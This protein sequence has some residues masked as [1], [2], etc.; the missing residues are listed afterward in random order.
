MTPLAS[1]V[2]VLVNSRVNGAEGFEADAMCNW[3]PPASEGAVQEMSM[4]VRSGPRTAENP[5]GTPGITAGSG[6]G[7]GVGVSVGVGVAVGVGVGVGVGLGGVGRL[8]I[9]RSIQSDS[10]PAP[11]LSGFHANW[12]DPASGAAARRARRQVL[13]PLRKCLC[14]L[15]HPLLVFQRYL[16][17]NVSVFDTGTSHV[18]T[19]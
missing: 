4:D 15:D 19:V 8:V 17:S 11:V 18:T 1:T 7:V 12:N 16:S 13:L 3:T 10:G 14:G 9:S 2:W 5:V 6:V